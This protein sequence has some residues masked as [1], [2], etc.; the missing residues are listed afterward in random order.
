MSQL[1]DSAIEPHV[2]RVQGKNSQ[3]YHE[4]RGFINFYRFP[5]MRQL[6]LELI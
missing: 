3:L 6:D 1:S 4:K 2:V 5:K